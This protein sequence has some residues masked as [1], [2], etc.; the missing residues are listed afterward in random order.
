MYAFTLL[1]SILRIY[2]LLHICIIICIY[3]V[4]VLFISICIYLAF[5]LSVFS[6][7]LIVLS[8]FHLYSSTFSSL[9][10]VPTHIPPSFF[11]LIPYLFPALYVSASIFH[12]SLLL[13]LLVPSVPTHRLPFPSS[14]FPSSLQLYGNISPFLLFLLFAASYKIHPLPLPSPPSSSY[15]D[16]FH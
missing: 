5:V 2:L 1:V 7:Y 10:F 4:F 12:T 11:N 3:L 8:G 9:L 13:F 14:S 16:F 6:I 15:L